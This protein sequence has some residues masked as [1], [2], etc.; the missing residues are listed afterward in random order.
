MGIILANTI[1]ILF[2]RDTMFLAGRIASTIGA[3][4]CVL[5]S[6]QNCDKLVQKDIEYL[7]NRCKE[8]EKEISTLIYE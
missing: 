5:L 8:L 6:V 7:E 4:I 1:A 3:V 2:H